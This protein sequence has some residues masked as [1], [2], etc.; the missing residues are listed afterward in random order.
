MR[1]SV[2]LS[3]NDSLQRAASWRRHERAG[4]VGARRESHI[5][6]AAPSPLPPRCR[7][8]RRP[9]LANPIQSIEREGW[10]PTSSLGRKS[11]QTQNIENESWS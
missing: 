4:R 9:L 8:R 11:V 2:Y 7:A 5:V 6:H 3:G 10:K 1:V